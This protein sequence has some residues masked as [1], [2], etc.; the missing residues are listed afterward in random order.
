MSVEAATI[1]ATIVLYL[2]GAA[3]FRLIAFSDKP[4]RWWYPIACL[5]WPASTAAWIVAVSWVWIMYGGHD[6][7]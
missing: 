6:N 7:A 1:L 3:A 4:N 5:L 2:G